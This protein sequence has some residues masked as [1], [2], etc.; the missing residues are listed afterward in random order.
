MKKNLSKK[1]LGAVG[2]AAMMAV[3]TPA[4]AAEVTTSP[5]ATVQE[6]AQEQ[7]EEVE[8]Q[9]Q[10]VESSLEENETQAQEEETV[11]IKESVEVETSESAKQEESQSEEIQPTEETEAESQSE[12]VQSTEE[13]T[14]IEA[15]SSENENAIDEYV[16]AANLTDGW[17]Q[18]SEG[19]YTYVKDG[20]LL[21][22]CVEKIGG[23]YY[24]FDWYGKMYANTIFSSLD[25]TDKVF[26]FYR[27]S[28]SGAMEKMQ[29]YVPVCRQSMGF[30]IYLIRK[31]HLFLHK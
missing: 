15:E 22:N 27:A 9:D 23:S 14:E 13:S 24:G 30:N 26:Y 28:E 10:T 19:N 12:E 31:E 16:L 6:T 4:M 3:Q 29:K 7:T 8:T 1:Q 5:E 20:R 21:T 11:E 18:D 25:P 2:L 17:H